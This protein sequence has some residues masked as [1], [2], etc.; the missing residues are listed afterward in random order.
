[1][2][3]GLQPGTIASMT[4]EPLP[5]FRYY[6]DPGADETIEEATAECAACGRARGFVVTSTA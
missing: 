3:D 5:T 6:P 4:P 2:A 1:M